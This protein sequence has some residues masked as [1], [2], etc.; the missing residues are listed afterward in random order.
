MKTTFININVQLQSLPA[1]DSRK[2][3]KAKTL[4]PVELSHR[5]M[6]MFYVRRYLRWS[7]GTCIMTSERSAA[8]CGRGG[9]RSISHGH[10][11]L[12]FQ[13]P[14]LTFTLELQRNETTVAEEA[15]G[16]PNR[17]TQADVS[18]VEHRWRL[19]L[20][21]AC[22]NFSKHLCFLSRF[23]GGC[24]RGDCKEEVSKS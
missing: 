21:K 14:L 16:E 20:K 24:S 3:L 10:E 17:M 9:Q 2:R 6:F 13:P 1:S 8:Q 4:L 7:N 12:P 5:D 19:W 15:R 22:Y 23:L 11:T 18:A